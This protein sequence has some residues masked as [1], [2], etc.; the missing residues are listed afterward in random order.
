LTTGNTAGAG[1]S[2]EGLVVEITHNKFYAEDLAL[3]TKPEGRNV[4]SRF[5][6]LGLGIPADANMTY[7]NNYYGSSTSRSAYTLNTS[8]SATNSTNQSVPTTSQAGSG[9]DADS[10]YQDMLGDFESDIL[11]YLDEMGTL[12]THINAYYG[13]S[14]DEDITLYI[15]SFDSAYV[16]ELEIQDGALIYVGRRIFFARVAVENGI[17]SAISFFSSMDHHA[18]LVAIALSYHLQGEQIQYDQTTGRRMLFL[19]PEMASAEN[20]AYLDCSSFVNS[21]YKTTFGMDVYPGA[22]ASTTNTL[23]MINYARDHIDQSDVIRY[24]LT[25]DYPDS[26][27][28]AVLLSQ[29]QAV[30]EIGDIIVYRYQSD[31]KGHVML[32]LGE[33]TYIHATGRSYD[34]DAKVDKFD[35][36][37]SIQISVISDIFSSSGSRYLFKADH[38]RFC[39]I[40]PMNRTGI[41]PKINAIE[42]YQLQGIDIEKYASV[43]NYSTVLLGQDITYFITLTNTGDEALRDFNVYDAFQDHLASFDGFAVENPVAGHISGHQIT[44]KISRIE[45]QETIVLAY[46][47]TVTSDSQYVGSVI[48]SQ[49]GFLE[50]IPLNPLY[51]TIISGTVEELTLLSTLIDSMVGESGFSTVFALFDSIYLLFATE[52]ETINPLEGFSGLED[53]YV[54]E[55]ADA[56]LYGGY[57]YDRSYLYNQDLRPRQLREEYVGVGDVLVLYEDGVAYAYIFDG[58]TCVGVDSSG[59]AFRLTEIALLMDSANGFDHYKIIRPLKAA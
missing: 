17:A 38:D 18:L 1:N 37:G 54:S 4:S 52:C 21:V 36:S 8:G 56:H 58:E 45:P 55:L 53:L 40:R 5:T 49:E 57:D 10:G 29:I 35:V 41:K 48:E 25:E 3:V 39:V 20:Y 9:G 30:L 32:Y 13:G 31:S 42:R 33:D 16:D 34:Y 19:T 27:S 12:P 24:V 11:T 51:H 47:M 44:W 15:P 46:T 6:R 14:D 59:Y 28:R 50:S 7:H 22:T 23:G 43:P 26:T 2:A